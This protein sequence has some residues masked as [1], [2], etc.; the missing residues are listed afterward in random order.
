MGAGV[1]AA[2]PG[3][4]FNPT[5]AQGGKGGGATTPA[6]GG[7]A[8][9]PGATTTS[10]YT[11]IG[12]T[13][14]KSAAPGTIF[15]PSN[16]NNVPMPGGKGG[17]AATNVPNYA[18]PYIGAL[19]PQG[20]KGG[21]NDALSGSN[22]TPPG[23]TTTQAPVQQPAP[24]QQTVNPYSSD[25]AAPQ[26]A[27]TINSLTPKPI[28]PANPV[29]PTATTLPSPQVQ[30]PAPRP[31]D[32]RMIQYIQRQQEE[33]RRRQEMLMKLPPYLRQRYMQQPSTR[34][35]IPP[36]AGLAGLLGALR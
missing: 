11:P 27:D 21:T 36:N 3:S 23:V 32:P 15:N 29:A 12:S 22:Y 2:T 4:T 16:P 24:V 14:G 33:Q 28:M 30:Q 9:R 1:M 31:F 35:V 13:G 20:G 8:V 7:K 10:P 26:L 25:V 17:G 34:Q 5:P 19:P 18:Q 6:P